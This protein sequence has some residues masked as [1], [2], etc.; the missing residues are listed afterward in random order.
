MAILYWKTE[1]N[2]SQG[3]WLELEKVGEEE[4]E[5]EVKWHSL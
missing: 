3:N 5:E 4:E 1:L 2:W